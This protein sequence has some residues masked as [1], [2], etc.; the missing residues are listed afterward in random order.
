MRKPKILIIPDC[1]NWL[2]DFV[3][4]ALIKYLSRYFYFK[5]KFYSKG[6][7][8]P[9]V[10]TKKYD[11]VF[12]MFPKMGLDF[13]SQTSI[14][15]SGIASFCSWG[16]VDEKDKP[17]KD[18]VKYIRR[19]KT[20][21]AVCKSLYRVFKKYHPHV[22]YTPYGVNTKLFRPFKN[23]KYGKMPVLGWAG[24]PTRHGQIAKHGT[25]KGFHDFIWPA[26]RKIK[27][28]KLLCAI[29][30]L[31][32][33]RQLKRYEM[34]GFYNKLDA[35]I[36]MSLSEGCNLPLMEAMACGVPCI[37]TNV[38]Q[39]PEL[40]KNGINGRIIKRSQNALIAAV[41]ELK[42]DREKFKEMG[43]Q[44]RKTI[45]NQWSWEHNI[46]YWKEFFEESLKLG[47]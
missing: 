47:T 19:F 20:F 31:Y 22:F 25:I 35:E 23:R 37:T 33:K 29:G 5:R 41:E 46:R 39:V 26:F 8:L 36:C 30:G 15:V 32:K 10:E 38:G 44:A 14:F 13:D 1:P 40:I 4:K 16:G 9:S 28:A 34:P 42:Q 45:E 12:I 6:A 11:L 43:K 3:A 2:F 27:G 18:F 17:P 7:V 21:H 24:D